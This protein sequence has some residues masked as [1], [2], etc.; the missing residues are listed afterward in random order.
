MTRFLTLPGWGSSGP[1]HWQTLWEQKY[2]FERVEQQDWE[3]PQLRD[4]VS[5]LDETIG[6]SDEPTVLIAH[7]LGCHA[8]AHWGCCVINHP[9]KAALLVAPPD[10]DQP[11]TPEAVKD[12]LP[13]HLESLPFKV[14]V[15]ASSD[16][17]YAAL[18]RSRH[19]AESWG[20]SLV[21]VGAKGHINSV[22]GLQDWPEG[23]RLLQ[24]LLEG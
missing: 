12:F 1:E 8:V 3:N 4:W 6:Q 24:S 16:D 13:M 19:L 7:S 18:E 5:C 20:G 15:V 17:P 10:L 14:L 2:G 22:S 21:D 9:V 11:D 23:Y